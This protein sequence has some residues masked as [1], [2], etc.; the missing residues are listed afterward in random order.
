M[1]K[2]AIVGMGFI[3]RVHLEKY[4]KL[5]EEGYPVQ[6][7]AIC[8]VDKNKFAKDFSGG[9]LGNLGKSKIDRAQFNLY[10]DFDEML[11]KESLDVINICLPTYLHSYYSIRALEAGAHVLCEKPM[12][13]NLQQCQM[14][15]DAS[16]KNDRKLMIAQC[17]RFW[18]AY[19]TLKNIVVSGE[20]GNPVCCYFYRGGATPLWSHQNW[21]LD[22][23]RSGGCLL[24][25]HVHDVDIVNWLFGK[26]KAVSTIG[27]NVIP[28]AGFD[29]L[30]TN[31]R[32]DGF[33]VNTQDDWTQNGD[34]APF[35]MLFRA[36]FERGLVSFADGVTNVYPVDGKM[37][38]ADDC[39]GEDG[40]YR[41]IKYFLDCIINDKQV[42]TASLECTKQTIEI[43]H[44]EQ[45][46]AFKN[47][48]WV[49][50]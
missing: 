14:M 21:L 50:L 44:A 5:M 29:A 13:I 40:Y 2:A 38:T 3:G 43:A 42:Q 24:D 37:Y 19:E 6:L 31:Y 49:F 20:L 33:V 46:S 48:E 25:Q 1:L 34:G 39:N 36:N 28:G 47:G 30:S 26:P 27:I 11:S 16:L 8:D 12:A 32:Y 23:V 41:E 22:E 45:E 35:K 4:F 17:L 7:V 10:T 15:I 18:P 9:N